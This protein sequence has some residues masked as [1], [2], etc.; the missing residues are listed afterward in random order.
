MKALLQNSRFIAWTTGLAF[1]RFG[2]AM[3]AIVLPL[4]VYNM[5]SS[6]KNMAIVSVFQFLPRVFPG[7][8]I[9]SIVDISNKKKTFFLALLFQFSI[10]L[11]IAFLYSID[12]LPFIL[13]CVLA[14]A[15]SICFEV[16]RTTEM[17]LIPTLFAENRVEA[18]TIL[19]S[20]HTAMFMAGPVF[21]A[22]ILQYSSYT[23]L[24]LL[25]ALTYLA[26]IVANRWTKIPSLQPE[27][28]TKNLK[29]KFLLTN[30]YLKDSLITIRDN[31][32]L[33]LLL[34]FIACIAF[35][36][37]GL[38]LLIIFHMKDNLNVSDQFASLMYA[39]G[40]AGMF[41]G[42]LLVP[43][44][45]HIERKSFIIITL[46]MMISGSVLF[47]HGSTPA[48]IGGQLLIF[49][50]IFACNVTQEI[51]IQECA[52]PAMLGR[53]S[54]L[55]RMVKHAMIPLSTIFLMSLAA[56]LDF[57]YIMLVVMLIILMALLLSQ[58]SHFLSTK[59]SI[60]ENINE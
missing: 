56:V 33:K 43:A 4:M 29:E 50:G 57:K 53:I 7:I 36:T 27:Q 51:L 52:P 47:Q 11:G 42:S 13:L 5:T 25:N 3:H 60:K 9:G 37:G 30:F 1:D 8:Y 15:T 2:N 26:P 28:Q 55:L 46:L 16:S 59:I 58:S 39:T 49:M 17:V 35:A 31:P 6:L 34:I 19:A 32:T 20:V 41:L 24:L 12:S 44:F 21:G 45:I 48:I 54:G 22:L 18:T 10:T 14:S 23:P 38:E 40:I